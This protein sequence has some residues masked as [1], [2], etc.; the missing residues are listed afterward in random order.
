MKLLLKRA[1]TRLDIQ[2]GRHRNTLKGA[3]E[4][5]LSGEEVDLVIDVG[6][7]AG[8]YGRAL[9][10]AGYRGDIASFEP[11]ARQFERLL[12]A[13]SGDAAWKCHNQAAGGRA[14]TAEINISGNDDFSS[15]LL[16]MEDTHQQAVSASRYER[17]EKIEIVRLDD[18]LSG[19]SVASRHAYLKVDTQ[20]FEHEVVSGA[21]EVLSGCVAVE[22]ELSLTPL[23]EGQLL[24]G[25]MIKLMRRNGFRPTHLEPEFVNPDSGELLQVN[26]LFQ[27][28]ER[29]NQANGI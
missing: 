14:G 21:V 5:I 7:H 19:F 29:I 25:E 2:A 24:I 11:V 16:E 17:R 6:A 26:G 15:S 3:R 27:A 4:T 12:V 9:R 18:E 23:Y 13:A 28:S 8:E 1:L 20:G 10:A 22:L